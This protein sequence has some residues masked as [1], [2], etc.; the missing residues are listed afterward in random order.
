MNK[1]TIADS[2]AQNDSKPLVRRCFYIGFFKKVTK[3]IKLE[4][5]I[6]TFK[7]GF[8]MASLLETASNLVGFG[9]PTFYRHSI[10]LDEKPFLKIDTPKELKKF[11]HVKILCWLFVY[12]K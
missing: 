11:K 10:F 2:S 3:K 5:R 6:N 7:A 8:E 12:A 4:F 9:T 1:K